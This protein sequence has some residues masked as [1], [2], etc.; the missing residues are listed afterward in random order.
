MSFQGVANRQRSQA[1]PGPAR[2]GPARPER[3]GYVL[4]NVG[5]N[6]SFVTQGHTHANAHYTE[7][8]HS[9]ASCAPGRPVRTGESPASEQGRGKQSGC[10]ASSRYV[11]DDSEGVWSTLRLREFPLPHEA[12]TERF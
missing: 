2:P 10:P 6:V 4:P 3:G 9:P 12:I 7:A 5:A 8:V 1:K 11:G